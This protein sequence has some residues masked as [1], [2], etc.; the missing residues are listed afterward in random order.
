MPMNVESP[1]PL[2]RLRGQP[3]IKAALRRFRAESPAAEARFE[4]AS[5]NA[6]Y[7]P[8]IESLAH[9][10]GSLG[11]PRPVQEAHHFYGRPCWLLA[12]VLDPSADAP[13]TIAVAAAD[14][15]PVETL[16]ALLQSVSRDHWFGSYFF[17]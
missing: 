1:E 13:F 9:R 2:E 3:E 7:W 8:A 4:R 11:H 10:F 12:V 6:L 16:T 14:G 15:A 5:K 17:K